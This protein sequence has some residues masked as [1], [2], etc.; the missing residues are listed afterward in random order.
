[1]ETSNALEI[2]AIVWTLDLLTTPLST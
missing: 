2:C 1:M